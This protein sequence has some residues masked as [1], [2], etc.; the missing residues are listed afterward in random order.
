MKNVYLLRHAK[1]SWEDLSVPDFQ[2]PLAQRGREAAPLVGEYM[3][4]EGL[5]PDAVLCSG[6]RRAVE[7]WE[8]IAPSLGSPRVNV[9][10][11]LYMAS[12]STIIAWLTR[13]QPEIESVLLIGHNP[14]FE[15]VAERLASNGKNKALKRM[16][17]KFPTGALAVIRFNVDGWSS[18]AEGT[19]YLE[20]FVRPKDL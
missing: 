13:L 4:D 8:L 11:N 7:T 15:E 1:S 19:G 10:D 18:V 20:R 3:K 6:A 5:I 2:R 12:P 17:G 14:G 9:D 16:R